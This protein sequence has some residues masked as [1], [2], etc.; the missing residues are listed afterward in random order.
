MVL[1]PE[2]WDEQKAI[3]VASFARS[4][5][6]AA[7]RRK[8]TGEVVLCLDRAPDDPS[9][10]DEAFQNDLMNFA[11]DLRESGVKS[12]QLILTMDSVDGG[13][14]PLPEFAIELLKMGT[15]PLA[16][17]CGV[18][19]QAKLGRKVRLKIGDIEA[20]GRSPEEIRELLDRAKAFQESVIGKRGDE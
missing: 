5:A 1:T 15:A 17:L 13:G 4:E 18:W 7:S 2:Q 3:F 20:E 8:R 6:I 16:V 12:S 11:V 19:I 14:F 9:L 10:R